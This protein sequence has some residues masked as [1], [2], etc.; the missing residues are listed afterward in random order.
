MSSCRVGDFGLRVAVG[1][2]CKN[3][4]TSGSSDENLCGDLELEVRLMQGCRDCSQCHWNFKTVLKMTTRTLACWAW[5]LLILYLFFNLLVD[6]L[7]TCLLGETG[8]YKLRADGEIFVTKCKTVGLKGCI[9][10]S[11]SICVKGF[12]WLVSILFTFKGPV[13]L[14][15]SLGKL[16]M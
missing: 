7:W 2:S 12:H 11:S 1:L 13:G 16:H 3:T 14:C 6:M 15:D 4:H 9:M 5:G 10:N 8:T